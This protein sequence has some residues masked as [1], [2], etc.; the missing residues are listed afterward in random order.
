MESGVSE[1]EA[2]SWLGVYAPA[3]TPR[4]IRDKLSGWINQ[5]MATDELKKVMTAMRYSPFPGSPDSLE[6]LH[7]AEIEKWGRLIRAANLEYSAD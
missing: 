1:F 2:E 5:I 6:K 4:L 3:G 7:A